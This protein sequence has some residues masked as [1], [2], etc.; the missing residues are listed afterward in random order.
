MSRQVV[1]L[2]G[3]VVDPAEAMVSVADRGLLVGDG[4]YET[5]GLVDGTPRFWDRHLRRLGRSLDVF[6]LDV[7]LAD[8]DGA[9]ADVLDEAGSAASGRLRITV[10]G[11]SPP[12][13][14]TS[15]GPWRSGPATLLVTAKLSDAVEAS[16]ASGPVTLVS[17]PFR[18]SGFTA[19]TGV[20]STSYA[21]SSL[22][23]RWAAARGADEYLFTWGDGSLL[24]ECSRANVIC[25]VGGRD[26]T[27]PLTRACLPGIGREVLLD[28]GLCGEGDIELGEVVAAPD[29]EMVL[30]SAIRGPRAVTSLNG[31]VLTT[32]PD[33]LHATLA[34]AWPDL[35]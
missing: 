13:G 33:G 26:V 22:A 5:V 30:I 29:V 32:P 7:D 27:P 15:S 17:G 18:R 2:N 23:F 4:L 35:T 12:S 6:G 8:V 25:R 10:T 9:V 21:D 16:A 3:A 31:T 19:T 11:G 28:A 1:W 34:A 24:S 20:K 14:M